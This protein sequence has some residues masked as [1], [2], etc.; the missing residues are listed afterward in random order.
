M[1]NAPHDTHRTPSGA[2][3]IAAL[4]RF[5]EEL[6]SSKTAPARTIELHDLIEA[7]RTRLTGEN[8]ASRSASGTATAAG[9]IALR[10]LAER[11]LGS[12][13]DGLDRSCRPGSKSEYGEALLRYHVS[14]S[15]AQRWA[16]L[17]RASDEAVAEFL[18]P[19]LAVIDAICADESAA[20]ADATLRRRLSSAEL[21]RRARGNPPGTEPQRHDDGNGR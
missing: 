19:A 6:Q 9:A 21:L 5:C 14:R 17:S 2:D 1:P 13:F 16:A 18:G 8:G 3:E 4:R 12:F 11:R 15:T 10:V 7:I 20:D